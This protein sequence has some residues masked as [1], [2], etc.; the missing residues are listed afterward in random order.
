MK[1]PKYMR[2]FT[3]VQ[4][5]LAWITTL[6]ICGFVLLVVGTYIFSCVV[7]LNES[8]SV[9]EAP[10]AIQTTSRVYYAK[11]Y[12]VV[13]GVPTITDYWTLEDKDKYQFHK[14]TMPFPRREFGQI[15]VIRRTE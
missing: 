15:A 12:S 4:R 7:K 10:Y 6:V 9:K 1:T 14:G 13:N 8:P 11:Q 3:L 2:P 5:V